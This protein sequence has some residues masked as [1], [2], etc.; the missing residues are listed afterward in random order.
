M[1]LSLNAIVLGLALAAR[2]A[3][4]NATMRVHEHRAQAPRGFVA[5]GRASANAPLKLRLGLLQ[6]DVPGLIDAL[7]RVSDPASPDYGKHLSKEQVNAF[8][9]PEP[10]TL[11]AVTAWLTSNGVQARPV[12]P[13][14]EWL[15]FTVPVSKANA[16]FSADF[17][18]FRHSASGTSGVRALQYSVPENLASAIRVLSPGISFWSPNGPPKVVGHFNGVVPAANGTLERRQFPPCDQ[19]ITPACLQEFYGIPTTPAT[20]ASNTLGVSGLIDQFANQADLTTFLSI[21][22]PD[23]ANATFSTC[24][25]TGVLINGGENPQDPSEAGLEA[26]LDIQYT[27]GVASRV[28]TIFISD[29]FNSGNF[30]IFLDLALYLLSQAPNQTKVLTT[31]YGSNEEFFSPI[32]AEMTCTAFAALGAQGT[33]ILFASGD[34]GVSGVQSQ[35]CETFV[36]E[37]PSG[38]P[39][40]TAVGATTGSP[41]ESAADFSGGG[42]SNYFPTPPYQALAV[43]T[44]LKKIDAL[45][46]GLFN[47]LG[48][49]FPDVA[50]AGTNFAVV[51]GGTF[52]IVDGTSCS[53]PSFASV[54][55]LINDRL[56]AQGSPT[57]GFLNPLLYANPNAF[58]DIT[59]G[60]NPGCGTNGFPALT[61]W[62]P[63]TGLG[64]PIFK[65]LA[66]A[67]GITNW[68]PAN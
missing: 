8:L 43:S 25:I 55:A 17:T 16:L 59:A 40:L 65:S 52:P 14:G 24:C 26:N 28:Q 4:P 62:D 61:G 27:V 48:R 5:S 13:A 45:N 3:A 21:L 20:Q 2:G 9:A 57:L 7:Y 30:D 39:Y 33:S 41:P 54:V 36:P 44:Y 50:M 51:S 10:E 47:R 64:T 38:C 34:G 1:L 19:L 53:S 42:F 56:V 35:S 68:P 12:S 22:R 60:S 15:E 31:S 67:A 46:N 11:S 23:L 29:G 58:T 37:Y 18:L 66:A 63:V 49:A 6:R 32:E